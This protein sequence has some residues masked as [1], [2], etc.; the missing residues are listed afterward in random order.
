MEK[1]KGRREPPFLIKPN[2]LPI[3][4]LGLFNSV[5]RERDCRESGCGQTG[6]CQ[7]KRGV[8]RLGKRGYFAILGLGVVRRLAVDTCLGV[9]LAVSPCCSGIRY[10]VACVKRD[11][12]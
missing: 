10:R 8:A 9:V 2:R 3:L 12:A 1:E 11:L 5:S 4:L 7:R 6:H